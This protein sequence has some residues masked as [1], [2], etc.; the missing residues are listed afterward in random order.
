MLLA[1]SRDHKWTGV[2]Y[3][4]IMD[5]NSRRFDEKWL[6]S[7][8]PT[9][10]FERIQKHLQSILSSAA[11][12]FGD[13]VQHYAKLFRSVYLIAATEAR[14]CSGNMKAFNK[15]VHRVNVFVGMLLRHSR[16]RLGHGH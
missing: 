8:S 6:N 7:L 4:P 15:M 13:S 10:N 9:V 12:P 1:Y 5:P 11:H 16:Q 14:V 3:V 2:Y